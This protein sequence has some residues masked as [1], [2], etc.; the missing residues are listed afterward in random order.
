MTGVQL[1]CYKCGTVFQNWDHLDQIAK[2]RWLD[3]LPKNLREIIEKAN[4]GLT[5]SELER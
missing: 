3:N 5:S 1:M 2:Q 4:L